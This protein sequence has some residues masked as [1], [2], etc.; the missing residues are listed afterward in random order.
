MIKS[1]TNKLPLTKIKISI[2]K[3]L[4]KITILFYGK[5]LRIVTRKGVQYELDLSEGID[6]SLFLF[7]NFQSH[8]IKNKYMQIPADA[9][10]IDVGANI[11]VISLSFAHTFPSARIFA[12]EP[13]HYALNK[14]KRNL[15]LNPDL[16][17]CVT[18]V[19]SFVSEQTVA[20]ADIKAFSSWKVGEK[21]EEAIHPVHLGTAK[22]TEGVGSI[23]LN[24]FCK[25]NS[26]TKIDLIKIDTDGHEYEV[27]NGAR[28]S[29]VKF[30][31]KIIFETGLYLL[32][33]RGVDFS[34]YSNYFSSLNYILLDSQ[35]GN[36]ITQD[37]Y[38][39]YIPQKGTIDILALPNKA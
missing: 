35:T 14:L 11:G 9:V 27:L 3:I 16:S 17:N 33:E 8:V 15:S 32:K 13:T 24:D 18:V 31:P 10:I 28:E 36:I 19:N 2:A 34:F 6:I 4:Y 20:N 21:T 38:K 1:I 12:F 29:I 39:K 5:E 30:R 7:G 26:L 23:T 37:N 25:Q 22:S